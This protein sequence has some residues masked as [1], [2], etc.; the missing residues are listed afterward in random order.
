MDRGRRR[1]Q[2]GMSVDLKFPNFD[3]QSAKSERQMTEGGRRSQV[4]SVQLY[5]YNLLFSILEGW[6]CGSA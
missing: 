6:K 1:E 2:L 4:L 5:I 3:F